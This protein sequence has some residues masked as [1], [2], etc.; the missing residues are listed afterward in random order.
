[1]PRTDTYI[2]KDAQINEEIDRLRHAATQSLLSRRDVIVVA[3]VSCIY[4]LGS[5]EAYKREVLHLKL[6]DRID[7]A[8]FL[9]QLVSMQ[10]ERTTADLTRG[11]FRA[12]G[13]VIEVMPPSDETVY[14][15]VIE[16]NAIREIF[17]L[18]KITRKII[19]QNEDA[20]FFP[21]KHFMSDSAERERAIR[22][23]EAELADRLKEF[24]REGKLLEAERL[25]RRTRYDVEMIRNVGYCSGIENYS[26]HFDGRRV[27]EPAHT[28]MS[29]F[30]KD[31]LTII[32][33][34]H[35]TLPQI[36]GMFAGDQARK[37][38]LV[39]FGFRLPSAKD[40][41]PLTYQE[42]DKLI[43]QTVYVSA[44]PGVVEKETSEKIVEQII[45]PTGLV[46]PETLVLPVTATSVSGHQT[47]PSASGH[48]SEGG[49][50]VA[51]DYPG[52]VQ[53]IT[54][55][56]KGRV[57]VG[58][59]ALVTTLTKKMAEDLTSYL[60][61]GGM[62]VAYLH[63]D[64]ETLDRITI[65]T[66]LR[67]GT[68]DVVVGVNLLREGLDLPEVSLIG[69]LD[70]DKEGFLRSET[71]LIQ[72]I[73][74]AARNINGLVVLYADKMTGSLDRALK[75]TKRRRDIQIA[76]NV[77]NNITPQTIIKTIKDIRGE[78]DRNFDRDTSR[79]LNIEISASPKEIEEAIREKAIEMDKASANLLF[80]TAAILRDEITLLQ[81][82]L[83]GKKLGK[84][85]KSKRS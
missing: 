25:M 72:T 81:K 31:F 8:D 56:I 22:D 73:G 46:D 1:M 70:A 55:R 33:E 60:K 19:T 7:R 83:A 24:D 43:G 80:E 47:A 84:G 3:S 74:R 41:R 30:P 68:Y 76:H 77:A 35:V 16:G 15:I 39:D 26:R 78:L 44:T 62:K 58:E 13:D 29:Y 54:D 11:H 10:Y 42:F 18:N 32:D 38:T 66:E 40:N 34:S 85:K 23:I 37:Q 9:R 17:S 69:V 48:P 45:R 12:N 57:S 27:G 59:R 82:E 51:S 5:P 21:A 28:L 14:R 61:E 63:S 71:S 75:E 50:L 6:G 36:G 53:D 64:V 4:G 20:W 2:E 65:L 49:D 79:I 67:K 52:Q